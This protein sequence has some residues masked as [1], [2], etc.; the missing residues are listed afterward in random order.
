MSIL[1]SKPADRSGFTLIELLVVIAIIGVLVALTLAAVMALIN[2]NPK[3]DR[4]DI[5]QMTAALQNFNAKYKFYPPGRMYLSNSRADYYNPPVQPNLPANWSAAQKDAFTRAAALQSLEVL[6]RMFPQINWGSGINWHQGVA[7]PQ[8]GV[9]LEGDQCLVFFLGGI[10]GDKT[11]LGFST[12]VQNPTAVG[13]ERFKF[14]EFKPLRLTNNNNIFY[15]YKN[16]F[17]EDVA[18]PYAYMCSFKGQNQNGYNS[19]LNAYNLGYGVPDCYSLGVNP[20]AFFW[21][22]APGQP[23]RFVNPD[24]FQLISAGAD[25]NFGVGTTDQTSA[26]N[27]TQPNTDSNG[28]DDISNFSDL[29]LGAE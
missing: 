26:W 29:P 11:F 17:D 10:P 6:N 4:V 15:S 3:Q 1:R 18:K 7:M 20:Y 12:N 24:S 8:G 23:V 9:W 13:G 25:G 5:S 27:P 16:P 22:N 19:I 14:Y 21:P 2:T 28:K